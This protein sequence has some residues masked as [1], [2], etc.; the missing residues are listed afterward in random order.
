MR[1]CLI[2]WMALSLGCCVAW[3]RGS[4]DEAP[5]LDITYCQLAKDPSAFTGRRIRIRAIYVYGFEVQL[6][7]SP[8]CCPEAGLKLGVELDDGMDDRSEKLFRRLNKGMGVA[9]AVF[10]GRLSHVSNVSSQLP[11]GDRF[12]LNVDRIE[13]VEKTASSKRPAKVPKWAPNCST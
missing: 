3:A 6:L 12:Q 7:K 13:K 5:P 4:R 8:I 10:V 1:P 11:S 2:A 9:M